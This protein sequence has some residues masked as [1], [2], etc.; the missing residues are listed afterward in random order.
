MS[1]ESM[2]SAQPTRTLS[3]EEALHIT[4]VFRHAFRL[5]AK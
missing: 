3:D 2:V 1:G 5:E 4:D